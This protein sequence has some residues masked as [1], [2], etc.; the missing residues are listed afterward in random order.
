M[1]AKSTIEKTQDQKD[2][3]VVLA[4]FL[5]TLLYPVPVILAMEMI[6]S[7]TMFDSFLIQ[8]FLIAVTTGLFL[9]LLV[10]LPLHILLE[11]FR[12]IRLYHYLL[13]GALAGGVLTLGLFLGDSGA[14]GID[15]LW[16][17]IT[18]AFS[19]FSL[20]GFFWFFYYGKA[21][22]QFG[23]LDTAFLALALAGVA[24]LVIGKT[25]IENRE[26]AK[27]E[28]ARDSIINMPAPRFSRL[29]GPAPLTVTMQRPES[30][31]EQPQNCPEQYYPLISKRPVY[32]VTGLVDWGDRRARDDQENILQFGNYAREI[33]A[34][35]RHIHCFIEKTHTYTKPGRYIISLSPHFGGMIGGEQ[36]SV[37]EF[38]V[39]V[40]DPDSASMK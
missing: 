26:K 32:L 21:E 24:G 16:P 18:G 19:G 7:G 20:A 33:Y 27:I 14:S 5:S 35:E 12:F 25:I 29:T 11:K 36:D 4:L 40:T 2:S 17:I 39:I 31:P 28:A 38:E 23:R 6:G 8:G 9:N 22:R 30:W 37:R 3:R 10:G 1:S 13:A 34:S 15:F